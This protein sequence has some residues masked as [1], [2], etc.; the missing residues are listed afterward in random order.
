[1]FL[2]VLLGY[3]LRRTFLQI[4]VFTGRLQWINILL[5]QLRLEFTCEFHRKYKGLREY[6]TWKTAVKLLLYFR[7]DPAFVLLNYMLEA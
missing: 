5:I 7:A 4:S 2:V 1:M 6:E 3:R